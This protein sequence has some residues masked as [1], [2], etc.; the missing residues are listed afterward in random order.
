MQQSQ[1]RRASV[2]ANPYVATEPNQDP[3]AGPSNS[4]T[5]SWGPPTRSISLA[6]QSQDCGVMQRLMDG[7]I[8]NDLLQVMA[9]LP[10]YQP[11]VV[12]HRVDTQVMTRV[13]IVDFM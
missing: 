12:L 13:S 9:G 5:Q 2:P 3:V 4:A 8:K 7:G 1:E 11:R 6:P 10:D